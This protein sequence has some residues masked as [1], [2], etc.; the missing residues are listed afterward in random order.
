MGPSSHNVSS[1]SAGMPVIPT[2]EI[3]LMK[4]NAK[5]IELIESDL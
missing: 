5:R 4:D 2:K 1:V 3:N